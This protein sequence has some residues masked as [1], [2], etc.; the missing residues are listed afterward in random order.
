MLVAFPLAACAQDRGPVSTGD[1]VETTDKDATEPDSGLDPATLSFEEVSADLA[2]RVGEEVMVTAVVEQ[3]ITPGVV[4]IAPAEGTTRE[5]IALVGLAG[6]VDSMD[7]LEVGGEVTFTGIVKKTLGP[8]KVEKT[9][10]VQ[11]EDEVFGDYNGRPYISVI[12]VHSGIG[13][14]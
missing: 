1:A 6:D 12:M 13:I 7:A 10:D 5:P 8:E 14:A 9:F 2:D 11:L 4:L 3:V